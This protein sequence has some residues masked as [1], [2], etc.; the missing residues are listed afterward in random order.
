MVNAK[1]PR[2]ESLFSAY[3][4]YKTGPSWENYNYYGGREDLC[5]EIIKELEKT[6]NKAKKVVIYSRGKKD[7][8]LYW[9]QDKIFG[10]EWIYET[11]KAYHI[12]YKNGNDKKYVNKEGARR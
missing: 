5:K 10:G 1:N 6:G 12:L 4:P 2:K 7:G 11:P 8:V 9:K 3:V